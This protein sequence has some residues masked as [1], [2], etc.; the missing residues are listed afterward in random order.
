MMIRKM[1]TGDLPLKGSK[2]TC[3]TKQINMH[4]KHTLEQSGQIFSIPYSQSNSIHITIGI[5]IHGQDI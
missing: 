3:Y 4:P 1:L 5:V 2:K